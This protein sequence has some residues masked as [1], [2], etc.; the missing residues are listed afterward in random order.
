MQYEPM[1]SDSY[2]H[3][4]NRGNN[5]QAIFFE[6]RN[7]RYL[8]SL[9]E[10][11]LLSV[12]DIYAY[13]L[14]SNHFHLL[15]KTKKEMEA[16]IISQAF[17]NCFNA[18]AKAINKAY[19]RTG[20]LFQDRFRRKKIDDE[21]YLRNLIIY[22]HQNPV[23]H[24]VASNFKNYEFSSYLNYILDNNS[25]LELNSGLALFEDKDNFEFVHSQFKDDFDFE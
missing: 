10:K 12:C 2:Y 4:F 5:K 3:I 23:H 19:N 1:I 16:K 25:F 14:L 15:V 21:T 6:T 7:Y 17:S 13:C 11:Y 22:I 8:L 9:F 18:Y 20:S 24:G